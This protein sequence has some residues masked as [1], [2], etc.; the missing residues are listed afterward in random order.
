MLLMKKNQLSSIS[1]FRSG[2]T[3]IELMVVVAIIGILAAIGIAVYAQAQNRAKGSS[4]QA[5]VKAVQA[6]MEQKYL[7]NNSYD[8]L[9]L[10]TDFSDNKTPISAIV[11]LEKSATA[12]CA[13]TTADLP[14]GTTGNC[15]GSSGTG[16]AW[17][18]AGRKFCARN[19]Q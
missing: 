13:F 10:A 8:Y 3:L 14:T 9:P 5:A 12:Y 4:A 16:C 19:L 17:D 18:S 15:T 2:F 1:R 6:V 11:T 7:Q